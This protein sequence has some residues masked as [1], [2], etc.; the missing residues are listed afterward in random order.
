M[1]QGETLSGLMLSYTRQKTM[2]QRTRGHG[3]NKREKES[4]VKTDTQIHRYTCMGRPFL[5]SY[6][7]RPTRRVHVHDLTPAVLLG[8][9][10]CRG[11]AVR[12]HQS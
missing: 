11:A 4:R 5:T 3:H 9:T 10:V 6:P 7:R 12:W 2:A 1:N 8:N